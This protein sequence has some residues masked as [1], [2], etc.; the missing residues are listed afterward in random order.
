MDQ[1]SLSNTKV[2]VSHL[3]DDLSNVPE[4]QFNYAAL[5][6]ILDQDN[7]RLSSIMENLL[8]DQ[9]KSGYSRKMA[10]ALV[11]LLAK[12]KGILALNHVMDSDPLEQNRAVAALF[13]AKEGTTESLHMLKTALNDNSEV[14]RYQAATGLR[15][16]KLSE[17]LELVKPLFNDPSF[18]VRRAAAITAISLH[19]KEG[20]PVLLDTLKYHT[21]DTTD[22]YG[23]N[24][25]NL[26]GEYVGVN[27]GLDR[28]AWLRWW[29]ENRDSF[30]FPQ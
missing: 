24:L 13:I 29:Q 6:T 10:V 22:N 18:Y 11:G 19:D 8:H 12:E 4:D 17:A 23:D 20:I 1:A 30:Q 16:S 27:F 21:L 15:G 9:I 3:F 25:Y 2:N 5:W 26:L 7:S 14:V 28:E